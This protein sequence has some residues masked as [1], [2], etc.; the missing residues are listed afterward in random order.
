VMLA[1]DLVVFLLVTCA[2]L[3]VSVLLVVVGMAW[4]EL[5]VQIGDWRAVVDMSDPCRLRGYHVQRS[6]A[7]LTAAGWFACETCGAL[8]RV[9]PA[10]SGDEA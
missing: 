4:I 10:S 1:L 9:P 7:A 3:G 2:G 5:C 6:E 8:L